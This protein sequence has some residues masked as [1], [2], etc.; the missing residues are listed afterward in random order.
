MVKSV[1]HLN[2]TLPIHLKSPPPRISQ[3][4]HGMRHRR[5]QLGRRHNFVDG[6]GGFRANCS[7]VRRPWRA[8][9]VYRLRPA[10]MSDHWSVEGGAVAALCLRAWVVC[11]GR[12]AVRGGQ[13]VK[14]DDF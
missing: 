7:Q 12:M 11:A 8:V 6:G 14:F 5:W 3:P 2:H 13:R 1:K 10:S 9:C 4:E